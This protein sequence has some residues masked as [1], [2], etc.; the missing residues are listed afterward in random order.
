MFV[1]SLKSCEHQAVI[2]GGKKITNA[3]MT[4]Q[5]DCD[6]R[7]RRSIIPRPLPS[8]SVGV[9]MSTGTLGRAANY[10]ICFLKKKTKQT[11][12]E[13][14]ETFT[15]IRASI[16]TLSP[17][18]RSHSVILHLLDMFVDFLLISARGKKTKNKTSSEFCTL[19][20]SWGMYFKL[21]TPPICLRERL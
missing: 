18:S 16:I 6:F 21:E 7:T 17:G 11:K 12:K 5:T 10:D 20:S 2:R 15:K 14:K 19:L 13:R 8:C 3:N 9:V 4:I 1:G